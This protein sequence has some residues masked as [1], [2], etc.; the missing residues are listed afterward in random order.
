MPSAVIGTVVSLIG[1]SLI[2]FAYA[3][4]LT[5]WLTPRLRPTTPALSW[6]VAGTVSAVI[7]VAVAWASGAVILYEVIGAATPILVLSAF[8]D[9]KT[10][11]IPNAYTIQLAGV[12]VVAVAWS[13]FHFASVIGWWGV[14]GWAAGIAVIAF[15]LLLIANLFSGG[16][17]GMGDVKLAAI[18]IMLLLLIVTSVWPAG[19]R[20]SVLTP[21]LMALL[22]TGLCLIAGIF[23]I[24]WSV[25]RGFRQ[26][27]AGFPFGPCLVA[28]WFV[29]VA[30]SS[31]IADMV[32]VL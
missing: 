22:A 17:L 27:K 7:A 6:W 1:T 30:G 9:S 20:G 23:G 19:S 29:I 3:V 31:L 4:F 11:R 8:V 28:A 5:V 2:A 25:A 13:A 32:P 21:L 18:Q 14:L 10:K 16:G 26:T 15:A 24:G 12:S